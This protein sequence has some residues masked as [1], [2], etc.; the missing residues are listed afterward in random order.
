M[1]LRLPKLQDNNEEAKVLR[2]SASLPED[3]K[4]VKRMFQYQRLSYVLKIICLEIISYHHNDLL[5][6]RFEIDKT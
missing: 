5:A 3:W 2:S 6:N 1:K 4:D